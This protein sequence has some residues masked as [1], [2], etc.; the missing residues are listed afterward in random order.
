MSVAFQKRSKINHLSINQSINLCPGRLSEGMSGSP[1]GI[2]VFP[3]SR[4][5]LW[6]PG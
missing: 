6:H 2:T 1:C 3:W 4:Y 5:D